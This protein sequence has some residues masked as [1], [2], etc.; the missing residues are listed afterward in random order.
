MADIATALA[1][2][3]SALATLHNA[4]SSAAAGGAAQKQTTEA[5]WK[6]V[7]AVETAKARAQGLQA[8]LEAR[9]ATLAAALAARAA[10]LADAQTQR[11][12][13]TEPP[14]ADATATALRGDLG[15]IAGVSGA[16]VD[17]ALT[18]AVHG[19]DAAIAAIAGPT[20]PLVV[21]LDAARLD[22]AA[23]ETVLAQKGEAADQA[24]ANAQANPAA[25]TQALNQS[26]EKREAAAEAVAANQS[27]VGVVAYVDYQI[28]RATLNAAAVD[29]LGA[30]LTAAWNTARDGAIVALGAVLSAQ[31]K[32]A[33]A[34]QALAVRQSEIVVKTATRD[35]AAVQAVAAALA[36]PPPPPPPGP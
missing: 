30:A 33:Q 35:A 1:E 29:T 27:A 16:E 10:A 5:A 8:R 17:G 28:A 7:A 14:L 4:A 22:L 6:A 19:V 23:K 2:A 11:T 31:I 26:L 24:L 32:V 34:E 20:D 21:A 3:Q 18:A 25:L 9:D 36:P 15:A 12:E 13:G